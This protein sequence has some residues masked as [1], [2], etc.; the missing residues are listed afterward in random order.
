MN[1]IVVSAA[2]L[3]AI[4]T[5]LLEDGLERCAVL[6]TS[7][8]AMRDGSVRL[9]VRDYLLIDDDDYISRDALH[10]TFK[11]A[12][13]AQVTKRARNESLSLIFAHSHTGPAAPHFSMTDDEGER[14]LAKFLGHRHPSRI[15]AALVLSEGGYRARVLGGKSEVIVVA[16]GDTRKVLFAPDEYLDSVSDVFDRQI[17]AFGEGGQRAIEQLSIGVVGL[18]GTGSLIAEQLTHLGVKRFVLI[19]PDVLEATNL[20][21]VVNA[22]RDDIGESKVTIAKRAILAYAPAATVTAVQGDIIRST[23]AK[24]LFEVDVIFGCT[25]S[26]GSRA[27]LQQV[28][29]QYLIPCIDMGTTIIAKDAEVTGIFGRVQLLTP[30]RACFTCSGLLNSEE[31]RRDMLTAYER[32]LDP[33]IQGVREPAPAVISL[34]STVASMAVTMFMALVTGLPVPGR[35][36]N[37]NAK[38]FSVRAVDAASDPECYICSRRGVR[39]RGDSAELFARKD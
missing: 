14:H 23:I 18:G 35:Y 12:V 36:V 29:Y 4:R 19:D 5:S 1:Q 15:H 24:E 7:E 10:A 31:V 6:F 28:S 25:D 32:Q 20:N 9:L 30:G 22:T 13:V 11:P 39:G 2:D 17:R 3:L 34:N 21:R 26:H 37:Y 27:I 33:Y 16:L 8:A 38:T